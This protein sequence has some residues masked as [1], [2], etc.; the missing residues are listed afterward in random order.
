MRISHVD[1]RAFIGGT[2]A[3]LSAL[4]T[5]VR[6]HG[7]VPERGVFDLLLPPKSRLF[8]FV[9]FLGDQMVEV[10]VR[11]KSSSKSVRGRFDGKRTAELSWENTGASSEA[12]QVLARALDGNRELPFGSMKFAAEQHLFLGFGERPRPVE[13]AE[14]HGGYPNDAVFVGFVVFG[15]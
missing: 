2:L 3:A 12:I 14:R 15:E 4:P 1:R 6:A 8:G 7:Q 5:R 11:N 9:T 10:T 13:Q